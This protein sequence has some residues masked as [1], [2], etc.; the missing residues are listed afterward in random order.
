M[1]RVLRNI[2]SS[3]SRT[4]VYVS[5]VPVVQKLDVIHLHPPGRSVAH[6]PHELPRVGHC[7]N[8]KVLHTK[9]WIAEGY[10][11]HT[12]TLES[13]S[14]RLGRL[15][16]DLLSAAPHKTHTKCRRWKIRESVV[17]PSGIKAGTWKRKACQ[18][19]YD[20]WE[21]NAYMQKIC[22]VIKCGRLEFSLFLLWQSWIQNPWHNCK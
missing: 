8:K 21:H 4:M 3:L 10:L 6:T 17:D 9:Q 18:W 1:H 11:G 14:R 2:I 20:S 13:R 12:A 22:E 19:I 7:K 5:E 16:K 15:W